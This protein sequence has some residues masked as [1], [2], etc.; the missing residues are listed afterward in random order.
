VLTPGAGVATPQVL[1]R[2]AAVYPP[3]ARDQGLGA[4]VVVAVLVDETGAVSDTRMVQSGGAGL[5]FDEAATEAA[6]RT[7]FQPATRDGEAGRMWT[8]LRFEFEP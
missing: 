7:T 6:R 2:P 1:L 4:T 8:E 3:A 5:G